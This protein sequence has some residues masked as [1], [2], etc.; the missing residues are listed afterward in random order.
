MYNYPITKISP[1]LQRIHYISDLGFECRRSDWPPLAARDGSPY[2]KSKAGSKKGKRSYFICA[3]FEQ[4]MRFLNRIRRNFPW[5]TARLFVGGELI[6]VGGKEVERIWK[7]PTNP[8]FSASIFHDCILINFPCAQLKLPRR[9]WVNDY[10]K[11]IMF[12]HSIGTVGIAGYVSFTITK[13]N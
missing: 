4:W 12:W 1:N 8:R 6:C 7:S 13:Y 3:Y 5:I 10:M 9:G 11:S 2:S